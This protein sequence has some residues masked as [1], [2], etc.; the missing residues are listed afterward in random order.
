MKDFLTGAATAAHQVEGNNTHSDYWLM[1]HMENTDFAEPS[2]E[3]CDHY[4]RYREDM[5][6]LKKAGLNAYRFSI[7][8]ARIEPEE[9]QFD[10]KEIEHYR[11][12]LSCC[13]ENNIEPVVTLLHFTSPAW[14]MGK[15]G[16]EDDSVVTYF[17]RYVKKVMTELG[18]LM[19]YVVTINE[20][21]M[22][23]Q[24]AEIMERYKKQMM[25]AAAAQ[26]DKP[27]AEGIAQ[28]GMNFN[29]MMAKM[30]AK[31]AENL[32]VFGVE[33]PQTFVSA[34]TPH[35]DDLVMQA[36]MAA[37]KVIHEL[38]P[39]VKVGLSLSLH[40]VQWLP[41]GAENADKAWEQDFSHYLYAIKDDDF[42]GVQNYTRSVFGPD[43]ILPV[44]EGADKTQMDY[45][46]YPLALEH[47]IRRVYK[48]AGL[49]VIVTENGIATTDDRR[50]QTFIKC[51]YDGVRA[52]VA[53]AIPV[54]GYFYWSLLDNFEWQKGFSM[55][56]GLTAV[57]RKTQKRTP[58]ES[59]YL[60]G[61][62]AQED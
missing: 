48:E 17:E 16:W 14:L 59:L 55:T 4:H 52:C 38:C 40:D 13:L 26:K 10:E 50:R 18:S 8:W 21:N 27:N 39:N 1:E 3:A 19:H 42:I 43:G 33:E 37:R 49:P 29:T 57:D 30:A 36:H 6:L 15:G 23:I 41:G 35:G 20:A 28:V 58:K 9:G 44:A 60:L 22:G 53:D 24:I 62:L 5:E 45:E 47:V 25:A 12:M 2:G 7:E 46:F 61:R 31:K 32:K 34:R 51:A 11:D 54:K 56:F